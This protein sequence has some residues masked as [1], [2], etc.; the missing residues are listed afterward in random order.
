MSA[1][2]T[3]RDTQ[4]YGDRTVPDILALPVATNAIIPQGA[5]VVLN[6]SGYATN[7]STATGLKACGMALYAVDNTGGSNGAKTIEVRQGVH[8][9]GNSASGDLIAQTDAGATVYIVDNQTVAKTDGS[10]A[11]SAAGTVVKVDSDGVWVFTA[12]IH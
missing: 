5:L 6:S 3:A 7:A 12:L 8:N 10:S 4:R 1:T 2:T 9:W 11:R